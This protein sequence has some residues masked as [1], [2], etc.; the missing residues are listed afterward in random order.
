M[1]EFLFPLNSITITGCD[2]RNNSNIIYRYY[3]NVF[4]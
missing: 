3:M 2:S 1:S 4:S